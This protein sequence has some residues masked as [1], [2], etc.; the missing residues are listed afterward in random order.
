MDVSVFWGGG[1]REGGVLYRKVGKELYVSVS[2]TTVLFCLRWRLN[3][4]VCVSVC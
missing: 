1:G 4:C 2:D 3:V